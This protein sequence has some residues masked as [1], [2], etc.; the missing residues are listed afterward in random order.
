MLGLFRKLLPREDRFFDLFEQHSRTVLEAAEALKALLA[1][2]PDIERHCD[3]I[4]QLEDEADGITREV[5]LAVR[6]SFITP[7]DRGDIK[8]LIQSMD[9][10]IDM[11]HKTVK[12]IRLYEQQSFDPGMQAMGAAVVE[13]AHLV[14]EAIP[15]LNRIGVNAHRLSTI[16]EEVTRVEGRSDELHEQGLK[17]LFKRHGSTNPMAYIIGSEIFGELEK[18]VD[19][20]EDVANEISGIVIEN[21]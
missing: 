5:L 6:R 13:A 9:D 1:G 2:G 12:T 21:V 4:V 15:L 14:A 10:A 8:D 19:R 11:M 7:F 3:R 16:A 17:D 20:F 18:V